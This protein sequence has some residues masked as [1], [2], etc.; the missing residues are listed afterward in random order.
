M[1]DES[2][3][4]PVAPVFVGI[5]VAKDKLD[6]ARS[7]SRQVLA[8]ANDDAGVAAV[9]ELLRPLAPAV[10]V[11]EATGGLERRLLEALL[12]ADLP[13]ALVNPGHVRH[14]ALGLGVLAKNDPIDA[15]VLVEFGRLAAPRLAR[16]RSASQAE[17][18]ALVTCRR[19][20]CAAR[21]QQANRRG[22]TASRAAL[23]SIDAV[24]ATLDKEVDRLDRQIRKLIEADDDFRD[25]DR[26]L[27]SAPGI[28]PVASSTLIGELGELGRVDRRH[29]GAL[30]GVAPYD[31]DSGPRRGK[32][33]IR[34]GRAQVRCVLY[35]ATVT[36]IRCNPVIKA[37][38]RRLAAAGKAA[39]VVIVACMRKLLTLLNA[40]LREN[41]TWDQL[42]VVRNA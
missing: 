27:R 29:V 35:M 31:D 10:V 22:A 17:L 3:P 21:A 40:M 33:V 24:I 36:A 20:L 14:L 19:Q 12:D 16:K 32:R 38:A 18:D 26:I 5:D 9:L 37:F 34:G 6:L 11:I 23:R 28:G 7:D 4:R 2:S 39:K 13:V 8:F 15:A 41:K 1:T 25:A 30:A 42:E